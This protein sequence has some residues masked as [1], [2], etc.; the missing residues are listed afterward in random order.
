MIQGI[1]VTEMPEGDFSRELRKAWA[2]IEELAA[3]Q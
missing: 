2:R 1:V 3:S